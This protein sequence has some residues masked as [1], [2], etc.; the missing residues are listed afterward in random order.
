MQY[1]Y[2][3]PV[4]ILVSI[5]FIQKMLFLYLYLSL[6]ILIHLPFY[7]MPHTVLPLSLM[8][9]QYEWVCLGG[10]QKLNWPS[11]VNKLS[12]SVSVSSEIMPLVSCGH[13][14]SAYVTPFR[15]APAGLNYPQSKIT[16][17]INPLIK[18]IK[19]KIISLK[20]LPISFLVSFLLHD[21]SSKNTYIN[22]YIYK[23]VLR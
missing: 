9:V 16:P 20:N 4:L 7:H 11:G 23:P 6:F 19:E 21:D 14:E 17:K 18:H 15:W 8:T 5:V 12:A 1:T 3:R 13:V 22:I 10:L 2:S